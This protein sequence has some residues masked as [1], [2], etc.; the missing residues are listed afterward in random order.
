[1]RVF[2]SKIDIWLGSVII[3]SVLF[4]LV[5]TIGMAFIINRVNP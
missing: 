3:I 2:K 5:V 1:M 4:C